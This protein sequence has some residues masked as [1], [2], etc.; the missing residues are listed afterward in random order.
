[1]ALAETAYAFA[2]EVL[3]PGGAFVAKVFQGGTERTLLDRLKRDFVA[4]RH[5]KPPASRADS[6]EIYV[7]A[8]GFRG[9]SPG[10]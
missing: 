5:A 4:V 9:G 2:A 1:M 3:K 10:G 8:T 6:A 7:V